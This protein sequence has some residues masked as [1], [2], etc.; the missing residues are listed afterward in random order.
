MSGPQKPREEA[1]QQRATKR[2]FFATKYSNLQMG[3]ILQPEIAGKPVRADD[4]D[5]KM[6]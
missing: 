2:L 5:E 1:M 6:K 4:R 3:K